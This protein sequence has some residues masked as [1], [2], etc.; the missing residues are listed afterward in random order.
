MSTTPEISGFDGEKKPLSLS[1][2]EIKGIINQVG[3]EREE[4]QQ[5]LIIA[6]NELAEE[7]GAD[8]LTSQQEQSIGNGLAEFDADGDLE[9]KKDRLAQGI[10]DML[11]TIK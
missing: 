2:E 5:K 10:K 11:E 6:L 7:K 8:P 3:P 9:E 4:A 1:V